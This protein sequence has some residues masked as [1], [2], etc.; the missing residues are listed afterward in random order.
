VLDIQGR[1]LEGLGTE[2]IALADISGKPFDMHPKAMSYG[3]LFGFSAD[4]PLPHFSSVA[5]W[6]LISIK[7]R[8]V[9]SRQYIRSN[10]C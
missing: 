1:V 3:L 2:D 10:L 8:E 5:R 4:P 7:S 6:T 9:S